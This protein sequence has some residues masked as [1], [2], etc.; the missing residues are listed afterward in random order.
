MSSNSSNQ[1]S[2][3][4]TIPKR[5]H[6]INIDSPNITTLNV[7]EIEN[8]FTKPNNNDKNESDSNS[9]GGK[10]IYDKIDSARTVST[11]SNSE[12]PSTPNKIYDLVNQSPFGPLNHTNSRRTFAYLIGVLNSTYPD[13]DFSLLEPTDF[14]KITSQELIEKFNNTIISLGKLPMEWIWDTLRNHI[15]LQECDVYFYTPSQSF[16]EDE[17]ESLWSLMWFI[18][19]KKRKRVAYLYLNAIQRSVPFR[20]TYYI[21]S[22]GKRRKSITIDYEDEDSYDEFDYYD[23]D[24]A[25]EA[26]MS[27]IDEEESD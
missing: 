7:E 24:Y 22:G 23:E 1:G 15:D 3:P 4:I 17:P 6:K 13:H 18:F 11:E 21:G 5:S 14:T 20:N 10:D 12:N 16:L 8:S 26:L 2:A 25:E 27:D 19:N 9:N